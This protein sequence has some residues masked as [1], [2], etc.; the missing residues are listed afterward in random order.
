MTIKSKDH[1]NGLPL[2]VTAH[3]YDKSSFRI[4]KLDHGPVQPG[5]L[6]SAFT[7]TADIRN[8]VRMSAKGHKRTNAH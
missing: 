5:R 7:P 8:A 4:L 3:A 1:P 2:K 6:M